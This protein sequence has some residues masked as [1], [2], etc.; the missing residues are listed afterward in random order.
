MRSSPHRGTGR[1]SGRCRSG[2]CAPDRHSAR[3]GSASDA[4]ASGTGRGHCPRSRA[5]PRRRRGPG[6]MRVR[7][8][9]R[10]I[11][12]STACAGWPKAQDSTTLAVLRPTPGR[13]V[14]GGA[15]VGHLPG[16]I[17]DQDARQGDDALG[18]LT[19][20]PMVLICS[21]TPSTPSSSIFSGVS[22]TA[23][24]PRVARFTPTSVALRRQ[25]DRHD[26]GEGVHEQQF[27]LGRRVRLGQARKDRDLIGK[28]QRGRNATLDGHACF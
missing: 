12:V 6:A 24:R 14:Q 21:V 2:V 19:I 7:L 26:Q 16:V 27:G 23:N 8:P 22:A 25:R 20:K 28:G 18:L 1:G 3:A 13:L 5:R 11:C 15:A 17:V 4:R 9:T 10:K